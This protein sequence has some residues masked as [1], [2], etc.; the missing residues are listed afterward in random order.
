MSEKDADV[1]VGK[2]TTNEK[3]SLVVKIKSRGLVYEKRN[4]D[5]RK[6]KSEDK[7]VL[8]VLLRCVQVQL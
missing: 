5:F 1:V 2:S 7:Q 6:H 8:L 3:D 4:S